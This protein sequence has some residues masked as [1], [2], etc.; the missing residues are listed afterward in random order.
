MFL[1]RFAKQGLFRR[2][3]DPG[4]DQT[5]NFL[6]PRQNHRVSF[7][8]LLSHLNP[9]LS[10]AEKSSWFFRTGCPAWIRTRTRRVK[11]ACAAIT[12]PGKKLAYLAPAEGSVN[13]GTPLPY[14][15]M[16]GSSLSGL[17][18]VL[19]FV[20]A[21][22]PCDYAALQEA[23]RTC[24]EAAEVCA[25]PGVTRRSRSPRRS[26]RRRLPGCGAAGRGGSP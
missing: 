13:T 4:V 9:I 22:R 20:H 5:T 10:R 23:S 7:P 24:A 16:R 12:P 11:V 8:L 18:A 1:S 21:A 15:R 25:G 14:F 6:K 2:G 3:P 17:C 26:R 19:G